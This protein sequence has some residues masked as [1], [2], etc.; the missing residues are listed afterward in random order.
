MTKSDCYI[1]DY[2]RIIDQSAIIPLKDFPYLRIQQEYK[3][4]DLVATGKCTNE[5]IEL[6]LESLLY[7]KFDREVDVQI[8]EFRGMI[9]TW[10]ITAESEGIKSTCC[11]YQYI[12]YC[13]K[14]IFLV[15]SLFL[16]QPASILLFNLAGI[17]FN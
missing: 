13:K 2:G 14:A 1:T 9:D 4:T 16:N 7:S 11:F 12:V 15:D 6:S 17:S 5:D 8:E 3:T 10:K